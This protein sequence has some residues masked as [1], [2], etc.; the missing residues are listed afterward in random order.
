MKTQTLKTEKDLQ[1]YFKKQS[2]KIFNK[3]TDKNINQLIQADFQIDYLENIATI[4]FC[5]IKESKYYETDMITFLKT[6]KDLENYIQIK[7]KIIFDKFIDN[8]KIQ[9]DT[10]IDT[11]EKTAEIIIC[12]I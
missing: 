9:I 6:E 3:I 4:I 7:G 12:K 8:H 5:T 10:D 1:N 2:K 11:I